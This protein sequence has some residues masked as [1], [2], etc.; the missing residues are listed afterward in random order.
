MKNKHKK[1]AKKTI[2]VAVKLL[3][4]LFFLFPFYWMLITSV[5]PYLETLQ[6]PPTLWPEQFTWS[7]YEEVISSMDIGRYLSNT[8]IVTFTIIGMQFF[9]NVPAAYAFARFEF[10]GKAAAWGVV[11]A[12][13]MIPGQIT[14]ITTYFMFADMGILNTLWPQILPFGANAF[15]IFLLRQN[16]KQIPTELLE[17]ARLDGAGEWKII[18]KV[19]IPMSMSS[20]IAA[21]LFSFIGHWNAYFWPLVMTQD[22]KLRPITIMVE[23][24]K[25]LEQGMNYTNIMAGTTII[26]LPILILFLF[27]SKRIIQA[28]A[29]RG[30]K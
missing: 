5:K 12:S 2:S 17:A 8:I 19:M 29:Y 10:K 4:A 7:G 28:M 15:A 27:F 26:T 6:W 30:M 20:L 14:F 11:M 22:D 13:F 25:D 23:R 1:I 9:I 21:A 24:I 18:M 16:F 3:I